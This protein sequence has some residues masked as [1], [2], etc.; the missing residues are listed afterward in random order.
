MLMWGIERKRALDLAVLE[1]SSTLSMSL[2]A[3]ASSVST[4]NPALHLLPALFFWTMDWFSPCGL[5]DIFTL[6]SHS[7]TLNISKMAADSA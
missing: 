2:R 1:A 6:I 7:F 3:D 5:F 4:S